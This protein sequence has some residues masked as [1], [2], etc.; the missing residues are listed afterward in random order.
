MY[1]DSRLIPLKL[2]AFHR[3]RDRDPVCPLPNKPDQR[4][5]A[6]ASGQRIARCD[7]MIAASGSPLNLRNLND[8]KSLSSIIVFNLGLKVR[9][10]IAELLFLR[11]LFRATPLAGTIFALARHFHRLTAAPPGYDYGSMISYS[12]LTIW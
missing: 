11:A 12:L 2:H 3:R 8:V 10:F 4:Q 5:S 1:H 7:S 9:L 6:F